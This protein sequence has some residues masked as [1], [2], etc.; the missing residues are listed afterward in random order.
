MNNE[1]IASLVIAIIYLIIV[2]VLKPKFLMKKTEGE[3]DMKE[4]DMTKVTIYT[5]VIALVTFLSLLAFNALN[6]PK[7]SFTYYSMDGIREF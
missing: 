5:I 1:I 3:K 2:L 7:S 4:L 6:K